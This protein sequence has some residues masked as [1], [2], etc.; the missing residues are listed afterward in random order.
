MTTIVVTK[1]NEML[2]DSMM[3]SGD[4][5]DSTNIEKI[6]NINGYLVGA[7][8]RYS[9]CLAFKEWFYSLTETVQ[10]A[11][12]HPMAN[13]VTPEEVKDDNFTA[14]VLDPEGTLWLY[15][16]GH[17]AFEVDKPY[18]IGT[19]S[20]YALSALDCD[21]DGETAMK[22]AI[23]RDVFSGGDI[24]KITLDDFDDKSLTYEEAKEMSKEELMN[25]VF[26]EVISNEERDIE[27]NEAD[28]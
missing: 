9:S 2:S 22:V 24:Q 5:I 3:C 20:I 14:L 21:V 27:S 12:K 8:G 18:A 11:E 17:S 28:N 16:T 25:A 7:A 4:Y 26:G 19:G 1:D 6:D 23:K 15:E 13:I 10:A